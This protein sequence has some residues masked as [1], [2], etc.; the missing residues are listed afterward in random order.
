MDNKIFC[1]ETEWTQ[2]AHDLKDESQVKP[3]LDFLKIGVC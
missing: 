1:L 2:S 3:L